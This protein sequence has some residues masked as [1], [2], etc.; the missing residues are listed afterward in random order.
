MMEGREAELVRVVE[1]RVGDGWKGAAGIDGGKGRWSGRWRGGEG[2]KR[3]L[4]MK[5]GGEWNG[6]WGDRRGRGEC[7]GA[8]G[9]K[10]RSGGVGGIYGG[11]RKGQ[12]DGCRGDEEE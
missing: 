3:R 8:G 2:G 12:R 1:G 9:E 7:R 10:V 6:E 11:G 5:G 4:R